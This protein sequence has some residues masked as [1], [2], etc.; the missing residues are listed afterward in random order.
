MCTMM[1]HPLGKEATLGNLGL[2]VGS[3]LHKLTAALQ[4]L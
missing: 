2:T 1:Q 3:K 4:V